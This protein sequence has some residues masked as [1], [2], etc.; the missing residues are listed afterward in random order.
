MNK[1]ILFGILALSTGCASYSNTQ[2]GP[3]RFALA[4]NG[5]DAKDYT[6]LLER[7]YNDCRMAGHKDYVIINT[8]VESRSMTVVIQC[9][10]TVAQIQQ[11]ENKNAS[12]NNATPATKDTANDASS[13]IQKIYQGFK[14]TF[15]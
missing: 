12:T 14:D 10:D 8:V 3:N 4:A 5:R 15:K 1:I 7:A 9:T 13:T 6:K 11:E 2:V